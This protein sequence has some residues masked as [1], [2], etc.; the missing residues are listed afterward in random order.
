ME[1]KPTGLSTGEIVWEWH[2]WDHLIQ[3]DDANKANYGDVAAHPELVDI[4]LTGGTGN[5]TAFARGPGTGPGMRRGM[6]GGMG[7]GITPGRSVKE[8]VTERR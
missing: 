4:N 8:I 7:L 5:A 1:V 2:V 3:D 6:G